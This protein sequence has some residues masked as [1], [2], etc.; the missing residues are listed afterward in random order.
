MRGHVVVS[1]YLAV[2]QPQPP[3]PARPAYLLRLQGRPDS[4]IRDLR[5][6]LKRLLRQYHMHCLSLREMCGHVYAR[7]RASAVAAAIT[8][9]MATAPECEQQQAVADYL[10]DEFADV[11]RTALNEIRPEDE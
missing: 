8:H 4:S 2:P 3:A 6:L 10:R 5:W 7:D 11:A 9:I 1:D